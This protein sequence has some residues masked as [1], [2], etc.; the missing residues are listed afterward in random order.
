MT[1][2][3]HDLHGGVEFGRPFGK[4]DPI[5]AGHHDV[6]EQQVEG[7]SLEA[8]IGVRTIAEISL[9]HGRP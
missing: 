9:L 8:L 1:G 2:D 3:E 5:H 7:E 4:L 6:G